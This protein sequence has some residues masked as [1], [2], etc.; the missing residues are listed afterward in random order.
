MTVSAIGQGQGL[1]AKS[2]TASMPIALAAD[3]H[4]RKW[5]RSSGLRALNDRDTSDRVACSIEVSTSATRSNETAVTSESDAR[6]EPSAA[7]IVIRPA[8]RKERLFQSNCPRAAIHGFTSRETY[9]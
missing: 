6:G 2:S 9:H 4:S 3:C 5:R 8:G 7:T 1:D